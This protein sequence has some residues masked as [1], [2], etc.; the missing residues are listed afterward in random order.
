VIG[1]EKNPLEEETQVQEHVTDAEKSVTHQEK[2]AAH[3]KNAVEALTAGIL[4]LSED[5]EV[6]DHR[7]TR[8]LEI[9]KGAALIL[10]KKE[11]TNDEIGRAMEMMNEASLLLLGKIF[12]NVAWQ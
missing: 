4:T 6:K 2:R 3:L 1:I 10:S 7:L 5:G 8:A 12:G 9:F 11:V